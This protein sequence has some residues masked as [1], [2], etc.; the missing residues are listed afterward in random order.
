MKVNRNVRSKFVIDMS[1]PN[2]TQSLDGPTVTRTRPSD[3]QVVGSSIINPFINLTT[4]TDVLEVELLKSSDNERGLVDKSR[5]ARKD[6]MRAINKLKDESHSSL[7][8]LEEQLQFN[9]DYTPVNESLVLQTSGSLIIKILLVFGTNVIIYSY[10][11]LMILFTHISL[12]P[13][14][15]TWSVIRLSSKFSWLYA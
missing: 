7:S 14:F 12:L 6:F 2:L 15:L 5:E 8:Y 3:L 11:L 4:Q 10:I 1:I 13:Y 9:T